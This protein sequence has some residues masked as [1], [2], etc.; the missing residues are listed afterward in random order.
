MSKLKYNKLSLNS[1]VVTSVQNTINDVNNL[2]N[3][4]NSLPIPN[5]FIGNSL[6]STLKDQVNEIKINLINIDNWLKDSNNSFIEFSNMVT[7]EINS[8][9]KVE[10]KP[11]K[12]SIQ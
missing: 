10:I 2:Q 9:E 6:L 11:R 5:D 12:N 4:I 1:V 3:N 8:I 7:N